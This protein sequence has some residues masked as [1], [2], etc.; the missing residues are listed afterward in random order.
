MLR[1]GAP[2]VPRVLLRELPCPAGR[3]LEYTQ[4]LLELLTTHF[5]VVYTY[6]WYGW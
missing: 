6:N 4:T 2:W 1:L 3:L 5:F